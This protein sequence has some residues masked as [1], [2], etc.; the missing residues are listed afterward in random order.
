LSYAP[1]P[2][3][4]LRSSGK[5]IGPLGATVRR[6]YQTGCGRRFPCFTPFGALHC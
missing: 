6:L 1:G 5:A 3:K 2:D 4:E